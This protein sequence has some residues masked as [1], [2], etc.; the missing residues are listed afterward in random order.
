MVRATN[1]ASAILCPADPCEGLK[2]RLGS[3][4]P[5]TLWGGSRALPGV[6]SL[7]VISLRLFGQFS[8]VHQCLSLA[9]RA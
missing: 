5:G 7:T 3:P 4:R 2:P 8:L 9:H 6:R 1:R